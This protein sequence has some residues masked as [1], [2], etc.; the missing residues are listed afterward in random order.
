M[1]DAD[2]N[3]FR[4]PHSA[5]YHADNPCNLFYPSNSYHFRQDALSYIWP[6]SF[7]RDQIYLDAHS[8]AEISFHAYELVEGGRACSNSTS[9]SRSLA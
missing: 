6:E 5:K 8:L 7:L 3:Y 2:V 1:P 4:T 9:K